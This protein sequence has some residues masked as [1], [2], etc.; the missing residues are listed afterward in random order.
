MTVD[1][2]AIA[3]AK[4]SIEQA[5]VAV[6]DLTVT[7]HLG[8]DA[9]NEVFAGFLFFCLHMA[10]RAALAKLPDVTVERFRHKLEEHALELVSNADPQIPVQ[11]RASIVSKMTAA[12]SR[13][14]QEFR[15]YSA[16]PMPAGGPITG[17]L[18]YEFGKRIA[19]GAGKRSDA[20]VIAA[21]TSQAV[22]ALNELDAPTVVNTLRDSIRSA[23]AR[24][25]QMIE[26]ERPEFE[27][28]AETR[29][30]VTIA[31]FV[32]IVILIAWCSS[33]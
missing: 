30:G 25:D 7:L 22:Y 2:G 21:V 16:A 29:R 5:S 20:M 26:V 1:D 4:R 28:R 6:A 8:G 24:V 15:D 18:F 14:H 12:L 17:N 19:Q 13:F 9:A 33:V 32:V 23:F 3:L 31:A 10:E 27:A 11:L